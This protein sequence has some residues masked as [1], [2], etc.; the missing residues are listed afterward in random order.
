MAFGIWD[1]GFGIYDLCTSFQD[2]GC[3]AHAR[4]HRAFHVSLEVF[5]RVFTGKDEAAGTAPYTF[6]LPGLQRFLAEKLQLDVRKLGKLERLSG[7]VLNAPTYTEN[8]LSYAVAY[9]LALQGLKETRLQTNL[10]PPEIRM[11]RLIRAKKPWAVAAAAALLLGVG[12]MSAGYAANYNSV[13]A[14]SISDAI[15]IS[16]AC[17]AKSQ[18]YTVANPLIWTAGVKRSHWARSR[19]GERQTTPESRSG[20]DRRCASRQRADRSGRTAD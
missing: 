7:E 12:A 20:I 16:T 10:L 11:E 17:R 15:E 19:S 6:R 13:A 4:L 8:I 14:K 5:A 18:I 2:L 9:G 1:L 3:G